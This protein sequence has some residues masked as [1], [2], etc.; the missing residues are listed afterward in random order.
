MEKSR[1]IMNLIAL[2]VFLGTNL[3]TPISY[4]LDDLENVW[5]NLQS[6]TSSES[7]GSTYDIVGGS[8]NNLG[9]NED[10]S[11]WAD[12]S[13]EKEASELEDFVDDSW[14]SDTQ[15][16]TQETQE[17]AED[18]AAENAKT[19]TN[20]TVLDS[21]LI[22]LGWEGGDI[23][24]SPSPFELSGDNLEQSL[25]WEVEELTWTDLELSIARETLN[26]EEI[27]DTK[28]YNKVTVSICV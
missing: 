24:T 27:R 23:L 20:D 3:L 8:L 10:L 18:S 4:A 2:T 15:W 25:T 26:K 16:F 7:I 12:G 14:E 5:K 28:T 1:K 9:D 21:S 19:D 22:N 17:N 6:E 13:E 11:D